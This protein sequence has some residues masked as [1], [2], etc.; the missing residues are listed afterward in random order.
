MNIQK[1]VLSRD[2]HEM[3]GVHMKA[4]P[5]FFLPLMGPLFVKEYYRA[6]LEYPHNICFVASENG[7]VIG[8]VAGFGKPREFYAFYRS[9]KLRLLP[10]IIVALL[11]NPSLLPRIFQ[12]MKRVSHVENPDSEIEYASL[13]VLP[14]QAGK[15]IGRMLADSFICAARE[16]GFESVFG[17]TDADGND[18]VNNFHRKHGFTIEYSFYQ[19]KRKMNFIRLSL[20][21]H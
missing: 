6:V 16:Q 3:V 14:E 18:Q 10:A 2:L 21:K 11:K 5:G 17:T 8:L 1:A 7:R 19:G 9:R 13:C 12:N 4:F 15:G 20:K